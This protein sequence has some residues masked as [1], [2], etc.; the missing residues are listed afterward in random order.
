MNGST[1]ALLKQEQIA[2]MVHR[3]PRRIN[4]RQ[5]ASLAWRESRTARRRLLLYMSSISLGVAALVAIDSFAGNVTRSVREQSRALLGGDISFTSRAAFPASIDSLLDSLNRAG[6]PIAR[7]TT[8]ASMG[9]VPRTGE[10]RLVQVRA[11]SPGYPFYGEVTTEPAGRWQSLQGGAN[12]LVDPSLLVALDA[13]VGDTLTLGYGRFVIAGTL[14]NVPGDPG[15]A[16]VIGPRVFVP[17]RYVPETQ[18]LVFGSR[19]EYEALARLPGRAVP[20]EWVTP[21]RPR[22]DRARVRVRTVAENELNLTRSIDELSDFL[23]IVGLVA[24]LLGG[25]GVASGVNAFVTRKIDA[26]AVLRC[27]GATSGQVL[28]IYSAQAAVMGLAGAAAGA[29]LGVAIQ[30][31]LPRVIRDF[32]PVDVRSRCGRSSRFEQCPPCRPCEG[33]PTVS[34]GRECGATARACSSTSASWPARS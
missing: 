33:T 9:V 24:L 23:G 8:F 7:V 19:A 18:L 13:R 25:I 31:L 12:A 14:E 27:L 28:A 10:T 26:V 29:A 4:W 20:A 21:F 17:A 15:I 5:L 1:E 2:A 34:G 32:L 22:L 11:V 30:F 6:T 16:A 3:S